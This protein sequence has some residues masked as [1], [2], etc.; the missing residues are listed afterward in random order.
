MFSQF[1]SV[2]HSEKTKHEQITIPPTPK[3]QED[4]IAL[5]AGSPRLRDKR[6]STILMTGSETKLLAMK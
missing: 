1:S 4:P 3:I 2:P 5:V 6:R